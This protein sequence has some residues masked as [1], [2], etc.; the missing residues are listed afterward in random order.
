MR[1]KPFLKL[2]LAEIARHCLLAPSVIGIPSRSFWVQ[3]ESIGTAA[4]L[5]SETGDEG[6]WETYDRLWKYSWAHMVDHKNGS[7]HRRLNRQG[8]K[9]FPEKTKLSLCVDPDYHVRRQNDDR[10]HILYTILYTYV[11]PMCMWLNNIL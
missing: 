2:T 7:W 5:A 4:M 10:N 8:V 3:C 6:Y 9:H 1:A 11:G